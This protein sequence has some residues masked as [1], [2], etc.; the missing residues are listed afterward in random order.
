MG[1]GE[2]PRRIGVMTGSDALGSEHPQLPGTHQVDLEDL[3][4]RVR[5]LESEVGDLEA[6]LEAPAP[7]GPVPGAPGHASS[8]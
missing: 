2:V 4:G 8:D 5:G 1:K 6:S 7:A 3:L